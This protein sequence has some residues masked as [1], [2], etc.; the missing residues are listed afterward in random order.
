MMVYRKFKAPEH[1]VSRMQKM[2]RVDLTD[3]ESIK[4][5][6]IEYESTIIKSALADSVSKD[7]EF[8]LWS[9]CNACHHI[10][11]RMLDTMEVFHE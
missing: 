9:Y 4:R 3:R 2:T 10:M 11:E 6:F 5:W 7:M 8:M 1:L